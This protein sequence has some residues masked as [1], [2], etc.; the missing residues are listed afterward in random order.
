MGTRVHHLRLVTY[1]ATSLEICYILFS[2]CF[3]YLHVDERFKLAY[4]ELSFRKFAYTRR[5]MPISRSGDSK[6]SVAAV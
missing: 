1:A 3:H 4:M 5:D 2:T 6:R